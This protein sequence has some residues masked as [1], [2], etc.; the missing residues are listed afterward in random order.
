[1]ARCTVSPGRASVRPCSTSTICCVLLPLPTCSSS[2]VSAPVGST[3]TT[4]AGTPAAA[5]FRSPGVCLNVS[6]KVVSAEDNWVVSNPLMAVVR[7]PRAVGR[8]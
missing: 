3:T 5:S 2:S 1:M 7:S 6:A 4:W 8:S